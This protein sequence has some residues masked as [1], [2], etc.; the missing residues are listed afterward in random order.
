MA[1]VSFSIKR[2]KD[3]FKISDY[4]IGTLAPNADD[5]EV[6]INTTDS[7][8]AAVDKMDVYKTLEG[9]IRAVL[10]DALFSNALLR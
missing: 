9:F 6:R 4:T 10:S 3:G 8:G 5:I 2:G 7:N 1:A